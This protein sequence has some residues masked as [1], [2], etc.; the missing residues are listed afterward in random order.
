MKVI[1]YRDKETN[2]IIRESEDYDIL[3]KYGSTEQQI[4]A[5]VKKFN[6]TQKVH[7][8]EIIEL[9]EVAQ[10]YREKNI[11]STPDK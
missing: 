5:T 9:D 10:F 3:K 7:I 1:I 6:S 11:M 2:N 8:A 4:E